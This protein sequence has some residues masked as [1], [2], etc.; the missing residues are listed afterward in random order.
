MDVTS[1][2]GP[3]SPVPSGPTSRPVDRPVLRVRSL[4]DLLSLVPVV[5]GFEPHE[6]LVV[7]ALAGAR[8]GFQV[9]VDLP[10]PG[11]DDLVATLGDQVA[12]AFRAQNCT[13]AAVLGFTGDARAETTLRSVGDRLDDT[14]IN[15]VD[16]V[17]VDAGRYWSLVCDDPRCCPPDGVAY[18]PRANRLRAEATLAGIAV[19]PD[20]AALVARLAAC[21]GEQAVRM[22]VATAAAEREVVDALGLQGRRAVARPP[23]AAI[24]AGARLG[25]ARVDRLLDRLLDG[26]LD[27][28]TGGSAD[29]WS[30]GSP[31]VWAGRPADRL[32]DADA[33]T[34]AV[35]CSIICFRDVAW[36]RIDRAHARHHF[37]LWSAVARRAVPPYE[38]A[39]LSLAGF[40]AWA[41]GDG[42]SASCAVDRALAADPG[43]SMA[44]LLGDA[45]VRCVPPDV[46]V[47]PPRAVILA[48][49][50]RR[51]E[52]RRTASRRTESRR[53]E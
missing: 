2:P 11:S 3:A 42:A 17:R 43:Y 40:A 9:R 36:S 39:V 44:R 18:D 4:P 34:L 49:E 33:A 15:V 5:L 8:P 27:G 24:R 26:L 6:S 37:D 41:S 53:T 23:R 20:R 16:V 21:S 31:V 19:A 47:P 7:S 50:S 35:W 51:T 29:G 25:A 22:R 48:T 1:T 13:R 30:A 32:T 38:P 46:W 28:P 14:G 45:L 52:S 10:P 12:A